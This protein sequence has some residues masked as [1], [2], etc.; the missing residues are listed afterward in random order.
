MHGTLA[1][2][3]DERFVRGVVARLTR[4]HEA[5]TGAARPWK[6]G[7]APPAYIDEMLAQIVGIEVAI[8]RI[9]GK[10]KLSQNKDERDRRGAVEGLR[11]CGED[12]AADAIEATLPSAR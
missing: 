4:A 1:I 12:A 11:E 5:H 6:M 10:W 3:D 9:T 2:R 8:T 7:D